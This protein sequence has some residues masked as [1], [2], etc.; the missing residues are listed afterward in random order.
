M[1][2][3][4][5]LFLVVALAAVICGLVTEHMHRNARQRLLIQQLSDNCCTIIEQF[6]PASKEAMDSFVHDEPL[7]CFR[8]EYT[9]PERFVPQGFEPEFQS[10]V[11]VVLANRSSHHQF[12]LSVLKSFPDLRQ[13]D[14]VNC[15]LSKDDLTVLKRL[16]QLESLRLHDTDLSASMVC[17]LK[18]NAPALHIESVPLLWPGLLSPD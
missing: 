10:I 12:Q 8:Y 1:F 16:P 7:A 13:L 5:H 18:S 6:A 15:C 9:I 17:E 2:S 4:R 3:L 14:L 11:A